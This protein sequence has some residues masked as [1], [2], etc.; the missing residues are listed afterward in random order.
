VPV[1]YREKGPKLED[2]QE[3]RITAETAG[4]YFN[5][6]PQNV[7]VLQGPSG[8]GDVDLDS[9]EAL[10]AF[11]DF[12]PETGLIF[13]RAS[14]PRSHWFYRVDPPC[15]SVRYIDPVDHQTLLEFRC[16]KTDGTVGLQT[17]VPP[18]VHPSGEPI[19]FTRG[20]EGEAANVDAEELGAAVRRTA[21]VALLGRHWPQAQGGRHDAF[22]ALAGGMARAKWPI[23]EALQLMAALYRVL[24]PANPELAAAEREVESTYRRYEEG[25]EITGLPHLLKLA[26]PAAAKQAIKWL[27]LW[28]EPKPAPRQDT[29]GFTFTSLHDLL[30]EP[31]EKIAW[32]LD[33]MLPAGGLSLLAGKPKAGKST[34]ARCLAV[35]A[36]RGEVFLDRATVKGPVLYLGL[37]EKRSEV[38]K[39]FEA[40]GATGEELIQV[41]IAPAPAQAV[42]AAQR[43]IELHKPVLV[44]I[45]PLL[46][47]ARVKDANDY[48]QVTAALEPVLT[49][50]RES[51]AHLMLVY[52]AGKS[53]KSDLIDSALGSTA[54][55]GAV[56]TVLVYKRTDQYRILGTVQRY[57]ADLPETEIER[58]AERRSVSLGDER[59]KAEIVRAKTDILACLKPGIKLTEPQI[60]DLVEGRVESKRP[61]LRELFKE[62][63][64]SR[65]GGGKKGDPYQYFREYA[66]Q[67]AAPSTSLF[68]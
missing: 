39:H 6:A 32:L 23:A 41:H 37:E 1:P 28:Q 61:A 68:A 38:R 2:W 4:R 22:L 27:R 5:G 18:S 45:D 20:F 31:E 13:G 34:L 30:N 64:I 16:L 54:F 43:A 47:F 53:P 3:L 63:K 7:G 52:H 58:D 29:A 60:C 56:D 57:G 40:L 19:E 44:I 55:A 25:H 46:K 8:A 42:L 35:A 48:A 14:K 9:R 33:G 21:A 50:A 24:W 59:S 62:G 66:A 17:I 12:A 10:I 51:G 67:A 36:A 49:L 26:D 15:R 65:E 11:P